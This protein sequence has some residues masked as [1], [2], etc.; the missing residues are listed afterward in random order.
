MNIGA[1]MQNIWL[2]ANNLGISVELISGQLMVPESVKKIHKILGIPTEKYRIMLIFRFG[3]ED[4]FGKLGTPVRREIKDFVH[5]DR[6]SSPF[7]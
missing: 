2:A 3:H 6:F 5:L 7:K 1:V 4:K